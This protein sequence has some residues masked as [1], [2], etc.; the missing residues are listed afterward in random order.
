[1]LRANLR[2]TQRLGFLLR[3]HHRLD[4]ALGEL[5]EHGGHDERAASLSIVTSRVWVLKIAIEGQRR[6]RGRESGESV[7]SGESGESG[8]SVSWG[9]ISDV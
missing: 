6:R 8:E 9:K 5:L 7:E 4:G 3:Q 2:A 1:V